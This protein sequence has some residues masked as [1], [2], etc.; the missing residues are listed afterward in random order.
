[1]IRRMIC[2]GIL[3]ALAT[4]HA[5]PI[6]RAENVDLSTVANRETVQLTIYNSADLTLVRETRAVTFKK[7]ANPLQFSWA[8]TKIDPTSVELR[9]LTQPDKLT[10]VDTTFPAGRPQVLYWNVES[11]FDGE[12]DIEISYFTSGITWNADYVCIANKDE[13][14]ASLEG[15]L[16]IHNHSGEEYEHANVRVV[17][18]TI[19]LVQTIA[20]LAIANGTTVEKLKAEKQVESLSRLEDKAGKTALRRAGGKDAAKADGKEKEIEK[21]GLSEYFLFSIEGTET[22]PSGWSKRLRAIAAEKVPLKVQYRYRP[23]EYGD[24]LVKMFLL[25]NDQPSGLGGSP[26]PDGQVRVFADNGRDG[27]SFLAHQ[28][29]KYVPIGDRCEL[30]LGNDPSVRFDLVKKQS[31]RQSIWLQIGNTNQYR[32]VDGDKVQVQKENAHVVGWEDRE[33]FEQRIANY[34]SRPID[35]EIRRTFPGD[36]IFTSQLGAKRFDYQTVELSVQVKPAVKEVLP[37]EI[38]RRQGTL[39]KQNQVTLVERPANAK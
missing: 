28:T 13:I 3:V 5:A 8:G 29:I 6:V 12:V 35:V 10:V 38:T 2:A 22:I 23:Q 11:E 37:Y 1:M 7:G 27:L 14:H 19:N 30:N 39:A 31:A 16:R 20:E 4:F 25:K 21:Q 32:Q 36:I 17:V 18:G 9:F 26:L 34:T 33:H 15:F 24:Q